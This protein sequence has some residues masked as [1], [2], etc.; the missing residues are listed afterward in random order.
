MTSSQGYYCIRL[1]RHEITWI[2]FF[3]VQRWPA[4]QS[5]GYHLTLV[6]DDTLL[7]HVRAT[8][9]EHSH[10]N[11]RSADTAIAVLD[12]GACRRLC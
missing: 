2:A 11:W 1:N 7:D 8:P 5:I 9:G 3:R 6:G 4:Y 12:A 10:R